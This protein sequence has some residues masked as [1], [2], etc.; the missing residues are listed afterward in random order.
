MY[1]RRP[2]NVKACIHKIGEK[3]KKINPRHLP[4][5]GTPQSNTQDLPTD[6]G[7]TQGRGEN[8]TIT[9]GTRRTA[10][11]YWTHSAREQH[12]K[13]GSKSTRSTSCRPC[14]V[15]SSY[16]LPRLWRYVQLQCE[17]AG[18]VLETTHGPVM[19]TRQKV[20]A[21]ASLERSAAGLT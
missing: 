19:K 6:Y 1:D 8:R 14:F 15:L 13:H 9:P 2:R 5:R 11:Q 17:G 18:V 16:A 10:V 21:S 7:C 3:E 4:K 12:K 20:G